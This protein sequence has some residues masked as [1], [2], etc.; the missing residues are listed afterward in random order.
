MLVHAMDDPDIFPYKKV[1]MR[2]VLESFRRMLCK[3]S[4]AESEGILV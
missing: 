4:L 3:Y 1:Q 2:K